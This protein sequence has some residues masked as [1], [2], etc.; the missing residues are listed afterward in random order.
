M[1]YA[2][3]T[4]GICRTGCAERDVDA[5]TMIFPSNDDGTETIR[6]ASRF[7]MIRL[8]FSG[9]YRVVTRRLIPRGTMFGNVR[10]RRVWELKPVFQNA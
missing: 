5:S 4:C 8:T 6:T 1:R 2:N 10:Y 7:R 3:A 9:Q